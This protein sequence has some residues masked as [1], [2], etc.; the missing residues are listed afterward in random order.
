M[1]IDADRALVQAAHDGTFIP[2]YLTRA[3][4][5]DWSLAAFV[6]QILYWHRPRKDGTPR[7]SVT[8]G[9]HLWLARKH[10]DWQAELLISPSQAKRLAVKAR[11]AGLV[12]VS[13]HLFAG[14]RTAHYRPNFAALKRAMLAPTD[15]CESAPTEQCESVPT[16]T[17]TTTKTKDVPSSGSSDSPT[18]GESR[19]KPSR[20]RP[21]RKE[22]DGYGDRFVAFYAAAAL[23]ANR[24]HATPGDLAAVKAAAHAFE[25]VPPT[26]L[27]RLVKDAAAVVAERFAWKVPATPP[28]VGQLRTEVGRLIKTPAAPADTRPPLTR[29][30]APLGL[31]TLRPETWPPEIRVAYADVAA[32]L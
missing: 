20:P 30:L 17:K 12:I 25:D 6:G 1:S 16:I 27:A 10:D 7:L 29:V 31:S 3:C 22:A 4:K 5:G 9:G 23:P 14:E 13:H 28:T 26:E 32:A 21:P 24:K 2:L 11:T 8:H 18:D 19:R 15:E